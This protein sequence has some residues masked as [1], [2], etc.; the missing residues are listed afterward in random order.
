MKFVAILRTISFVRDYAF[1]AT[2]HGKS[3]PRGAAKIPEIPPT[4]LCK[5]GARGDLSRMRGIILSYQ[6]VG[7]S[8]ALSA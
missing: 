1:S 6:H 3:G 2:S 4:P 7:S 5:R 8:L